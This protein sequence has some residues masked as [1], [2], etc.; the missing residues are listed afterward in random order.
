MLVCLLLNLK[1]KVGETDLVTMELK[2][3]PGPAI[4]QKVRPLNPAMKSSL[5]AQIADWIENGV[6]TNSV[7]EY[8]PP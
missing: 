8:R 7:S 2:M 1:K 4:R 3:K 6:I 5:D